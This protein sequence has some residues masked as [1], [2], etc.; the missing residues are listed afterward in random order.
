MPLERDHGTPT[1][2]EPS[3][4]GLTP[5]D[6]DE[7]IPRQ[8]P[9]VHGADRETAVPIND[10][11]PPEF[12]IRGASTARTG[13]ND[14]ERPNAASELEDL[15][16]WAKETEEKEELNSLRELQ[17]RYNMRD[18]SALLLFQK[19]PAHIPK[20]Q[21][22]SSSQLPRPE[23][24]QKYAKA[25]RAEYNRWER[26]CEGFFLR[27][28]DSFLTEEQKVDFGSRY[29][30]E[31]LKTLWRS[32][33]ASNLHNNPFWTPTWATLKATMLDALGT[34]AERKQ[35]AYEAL[36]R[37]RQLPKQSPTDLLDYMRPLWEE[38][39]SSHTAELQVLEYVSA[40]L[41]EI[42]RD[43]FLTPYDQRN[44]I[45]K[46]EEQANIISRRRTHQGP[47]IGEKTQERH[48]SYK[49]GP[50][51]H[52]ASESEA[53][54]SSKTL[55]ISREVKTGRKWAGKSLTARRETKKL[56]NACWVC[57][58]TGHWRDDCPR[59]K[60]KGKDSPEDKSGKDKGQRS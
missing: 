6:A 39:G 56:P 41:P 32:H 26:D 35:A 28:P 36:K 20:S 49:K 1:R 18:P 17:R 16:R 11:N 55:K 34:S 4:G 23:P 13:R 29:L 57:G 53:E 21:V 12:H 43:L 2:D 30:T 9:S 58:E 5:S 10:E 47:Q 14:P 7:E 37:C 3:S 44:T 45:P 33:C 38:L 52:K 19:G 22:G 50:K 42:Q 54:G 27:S 40:L 59:N 60:G 48:N 31:N 24:P 15:R 46:V 51:K 8:T 25:N